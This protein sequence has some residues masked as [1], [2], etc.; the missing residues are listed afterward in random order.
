MKKIIVFG[1][2]QL[3][4]NCINLLEK[5]NQV[6]LEAVIGCET[7]QDIKQGYPSVKSFCQDNRI[8]YYNPAKLDSNFL[9]VFKSLNP[10]LCFSIMYRNIFPQSFI[11]IPKMGFINL[12]P[13]LLPKYRGPIPWV[14]AMLNGEQEVGVTLHYIDEGIDSG[15]I[16]NQTSTTIDESITGYELLLKLTDAGTKI[17]KDQ[18]PMILKGTNRR[19]EQNHILASY[20]GPFSDK[21]RIINWYES[22]NL[23]IRRINVVTHPYKGAISNLLDSQ[24]LIWKASQIKRL[25]NKLSGPGK[26]VEVLDNNQFIVSTVDGYILIMDYTI[27]EN[28]SRQLQKLIRVGN[29]L[30]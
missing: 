27:A 14:W 29:L 30:N 18:L 7:E 13:S 25:K 2:H 23:I 17:F 9:E 1:N 3:A 15:E 12:H 28:S 11:K 4:I 21:I 8:K 10:D 26:I 24:I 5:S 6:D 19:Q 20:Y 22:T 16:I